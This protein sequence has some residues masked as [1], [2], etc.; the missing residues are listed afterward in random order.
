MEWKPITYETLIKHIELLEYLFSEE[1]KSFWNFIKIKPEK[2]TEATM[3][4]EG[5]GF[6]AVALFGHRVLYY[7]DIEEGFNISTYRKYGVIDEYYAGQGE[8]DKLI[9]GLFDEIKRGVLP[10]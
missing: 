5:N 6:W 3:G 9:G 10:W 2:W 8:L 4:K 7:N 1:Q